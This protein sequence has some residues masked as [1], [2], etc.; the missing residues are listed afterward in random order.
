MTIFKSERD[1]GLVCR[2]KT[3]VYFQSFVAALVPPP[4]DTVGT[5]GGMNKVGC[6][7]CSSCRQTCRG[8]LSCH[9]EH[10]HVAE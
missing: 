5:L 2:L 9:L 4:A 6:F 8:D 3:R 1:L 7:C 10:W